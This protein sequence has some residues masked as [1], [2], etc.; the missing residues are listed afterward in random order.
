MASA[1]KTN[2]GSWRTL[3]CKTIDGKKVRKSFTVSPEEF[4]G[5]PK[6]KSRKAKMQSELLAREWTFSKEEE[7]RYTTVSKAITA[8][9]ESRADAW[10]P[11][12][13]KDYLNM[14]KHFEDISHIDVNELESKH[15]QGLINKWSKSG[16]SSKT[17]TNRVNFLKSC[18]KE[19]KVKTEFDILIPPTAPPILEP[20]E[21]SEFHRLL[22]IAS[23][24]ERLVIILAGLYTLRRGEIGG[25]CGEDMLWDMNSIYVHTSR[26]KNSEKKWVRKAIPK[27]LVSIRTI[28]ID[29]EIMKLFPKV[30]P[31]EY[32]IKMNPDEMTHHFIKLRKKAGV[33][34]R[35]HDLRKYAASIRSEIM[36]GKYIEADGGWRK[37]SNVMKNI[38]DKPFKEKR[39]EYSKKLN[40]QII[41]EYGR[42]LFG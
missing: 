25:L 38:Y 42:D 39:N 40:A 33:H 26:V 5:S 24:E 10:S 7:V 29:P 6:E 18:L 22:N 31:K 30:A 34:C 8:F 9:L 41:E 2:N 12:T 21:P 36:P 27:K 3:A 14:P 4:S 11:S 16:L 37:D 35:L 28:R 1:T 20:P 17:T 15:I 13:Y 19:A 23:P 32:V